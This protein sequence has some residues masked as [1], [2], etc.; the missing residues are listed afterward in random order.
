MRLKVLLILFISLICLSGKSQTT[1]IHEQ[2][3]K[4]L[5]ANNKSRLDPSVLKDIMYQDIMG[6]ENINDETSI[7]INDILK[8]S[9]SHI[10]KKYVHAT[11]GPNTFDCSGFTSY[12]Y[13]Q[14]GYKINTGVVSQYGQGESIKKQNARKG[15]LIFFQNR[16][17]TRVGHVG[18]IWS[19][20]EDGTITFIHASISGVKISELKGYYTERFV[21]IKRIIK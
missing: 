1:K 4:E 11:H 9:K 2:T 6:K 20:E 16:Q 7:L 12:V 10:G 19:I 3:H 8:E 18:I 13:K 14:F 17:K 5:I 15:D 21:G